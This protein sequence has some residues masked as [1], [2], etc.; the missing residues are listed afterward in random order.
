M[1]FRFYFDTF[2]FISLQMPVSA[3]SI[4]KDTKKNS[5]IVCIVEDLTKKIRPL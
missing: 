4:C 1:L 3:T 2:L 5:Y